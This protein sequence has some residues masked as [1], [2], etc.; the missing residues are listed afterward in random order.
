MLH[1]IQMKFAGLIY[2]SLTYLIALLQFY[3]Y[4]VIWKENQ[5]CL[6]PK[7]IA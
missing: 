7:Y 4:L 6:L 5:D 2:K 3:F 1:P